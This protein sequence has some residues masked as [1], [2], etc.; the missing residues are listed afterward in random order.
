LQSMVNQQVIPKP[1]VCIW[2][3]IKPHMKVIAKPL[4]SG[5]DPTRNRPFP[6]EEHMK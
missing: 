6:R 1:E 4:I 5:S 2:E 3:N